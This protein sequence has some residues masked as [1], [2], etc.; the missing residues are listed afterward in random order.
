[1]KKYNMK[2]VMQFIYK[3]ICI[4][5]QYPLKSKCHQFQHYVNKNQ[6]GAAVPSAITDDS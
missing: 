4:Y 1:M 2:Y 3:Y 6:T 5:L